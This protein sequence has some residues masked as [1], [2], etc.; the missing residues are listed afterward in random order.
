[1]NKPLARAHMKRSHLR[2]RFLNSRSEVNRIS[3]IK[4][5][6]F[7]ILSLLRKTKKQYNANWNEK[8][9]AD[10]KKFWKSVISLLSNKLKSNEKITLVKNDKIFTQDIKVTE[11]L[12]SF[13]SSVVKNLKVSEYSKT[14]PLAEEIANPVL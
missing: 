14:N 12:N 7:C 4:Q 6:S 2:N 11:E 8:D 9:V 10:N 1:M 5:R 3:F 13:F